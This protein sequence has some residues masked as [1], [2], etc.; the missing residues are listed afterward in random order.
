[1]AIEAI[2]LGLDGVIFDTEEAHL[3][4]TNTAFERS[5]MDLRWELQQFREAARVHGAGNAPVAVLEKLS[6]PLS[7]REAHALLQEKHAAFRELILSAPPSV[8][9]GFAGLMNDALES[10]CKLAIVTD[11]PVQTSTCLLDQAFSDSVTRLFSV[12]I[13]GA[14]FSDAC[15][16][17][18]YHLAMRT[19]GV[20]AEECVAIDASA[21]ALRTAQQ[22]G[23]WTVAVTPYQKD[24]ARITGADIWCPQ[25]QEL[26]DLVGRRSAAREQAKRF[27][28][29]DALRS[30]KKDRLG[31]MPVLRKP[32]QLQP[33]A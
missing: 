5:G 9:P 33:Y 12:V 11:L 16:N 22:A 17:G 6:L 7:G 8:H 25:L 4:A 13:S 19:M 31:E 29:F 32:V 15:D 1:M 28:T 23:I 20:E 30:L 14:D 24:V 3:A 18:P 21:P 10:G 2:T 27:L 26:R